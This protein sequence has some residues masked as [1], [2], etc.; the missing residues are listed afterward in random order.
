MEKMH[1]KWKKCTVIKLALSLK[2][3]LSVQVL[4]SLSVPV[5]SFFFRLHFLFFRSF[6]FL[7]RFL[8]STF[9]FWRTRAPIGDTSTSFCVVTQQVL[10]CVTRRHQ[11]GVHDAPHDGDL[12][13]VGLWEGVRNALIRP[14]G[15]QSSRHSAHQHV[16]LP[17]V[18]A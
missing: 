3:T 11:I 15:A 17:V 1:G 18:S 16:G 8:L 10:V 2:L 9:L 14:Q 4:L 13:H 12:V 6:S 5:L 7:F